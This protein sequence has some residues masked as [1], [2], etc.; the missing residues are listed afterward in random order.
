MAVPYNVLAR[1]VESDRT[2]Y[3]SV[4]NRLKETD[5]TKGVNP[6]FI[7]VVE[8]AL[9]SAAPARP[10]K[11]LVLAG[12]LL[13]G[14]VLGS[15]LA[16]ALLALDTSLKTVDQVETYTGVPVLTAISKSPEPL[17]A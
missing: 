15:C 2:L 17:A 11:K 9:P 8:P 13:G 4:L 12:G 5:V 10:R 6:N 1:E 3:E 14:L 7:E 16:L